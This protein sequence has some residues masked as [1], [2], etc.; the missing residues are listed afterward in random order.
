MYNVSMDNIISFIKLY[1]A[2]FLTILVHLIGG[3]DV[4][5]ITLMTF[6]VLDYVT[7]MAK[8]YQSKSLDSNVGFKGVI[9]KCGELIVV[10]VGV[11]IDNF[12]QTGGFMRELV[13]Y[14][15]VL[16]EALSIIENLGSLGVP[17]PKKFKDALAQLREEKE[18]LNL[19]E[20]ENGKE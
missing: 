1:L 17:I 3:I 9:K 14:Y 10:M 8:A 2:G 11:G 6:M 20:K 12:L 5:I 16:T 13:I 7:G 18:S 19:K 4:A 15:L